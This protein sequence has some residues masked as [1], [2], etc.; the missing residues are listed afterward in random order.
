MACIKYSCCKIVNHVTQAV[1][2]TTHLMSKKWDFVEPNRFIS[3]RQMRISYG[4]EMMEQ[5]HVG[6]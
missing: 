6:E 3:Q 4:Q 2:K 5:P 1:D